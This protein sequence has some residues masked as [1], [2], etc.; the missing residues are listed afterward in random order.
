MQAF[1]PEE[2]PAGKHPEVL[3][4]DRGTLHVSAGILPQTS[5]HFFLYNIC[6]IGNLI[7]NYEKKN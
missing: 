7:N 4:K 3:W 6:F 1:T 5:S 2:K